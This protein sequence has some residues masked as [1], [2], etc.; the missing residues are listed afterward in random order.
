MYF[1]C[2]Y[3]NWLNVEIFYFKNLSW[4]DHRLQSQNELDL[5]H[6]HKFLKDLHLLFQHRFLSQI[7]IYLLKVGFK[8]NDSQ[9]M[10]YIFKACFELRLQ[11]LLLLF[12]CPVIYY[13]V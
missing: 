1:F 9:L 13:G 5:L 8:Y 10:S 7:S 12:L 11:M 4:C 2:L 3:Y 6:I